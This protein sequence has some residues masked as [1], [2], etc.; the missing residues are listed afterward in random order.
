MRRSRFREEQII[1][2]LWEQEARGRRW[3]MSAARTGSAKRRFQVEGQVRRDRGF[4]G[5]AGESAAGRELLAEA[6]L[7]NAML[8]HVAAKNGDGRRQTRGRLSPSRRPRSEPAAG[9]TGAVGA[10]RGSDPLLPAA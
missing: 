9:H 7:D 10:D 5:P 4:T 2:I 6:M 1:A 3:R 8:G